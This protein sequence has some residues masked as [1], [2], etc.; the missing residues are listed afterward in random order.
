MSTPTDKT[1][2]SESEPN[3]AHERCA[4]PLPDQAKKR[5]AQRKRPVHSKPRNPRYVSARRSDGGLFYVRRLP[6]ALINAGLFPAQNPTIRLALGTKDW[7]IAQAKARQMTA[8]FDREWSR[9]VKNLKTAAPAGIPANA[10][11]LRADDIPV[12]SRRLES[13]LVHT[14][15]VDRSRV[16]SADDFETYDSDLATQRKQLR[17]ANQRG[18]VAAVAEE[19]LGFLEAEG[20][21]CEPSSPMWTDWLRAVLQAHLSALSRIASRLD[22]EAVPTPPPVAPMRSEDDL[23]DLDRALVYWQTKTGPQ[24]KTV[25]EMRSCVER[26]RLATGRTRISAVRPDDVVTFM[27]VERERPSAR[28]GQVNVQT[29]NKGLALLKAL[30]SLV[31]ADYLSAQNV[32]NPLSSIK[33][34]RVRARDVARRKQ[35]SEEQLVR[36]FSGPVH[37]AASRPAGGAGEAAYWAPVLGYTSGARMQE[38]LQA[39]VSDVVMMDGVVLLRTETEDDEDDEDTDVD[40]KE[41]DAR[42]CSRRSLKTSE[43]YRFIPLHRDVLALGFM[44]YVEWVRDAGHVQ[45][46][47]DVRVGIH[48]SWSANFSKFF[49]RYLKQRG[50]KERLLDWI[51]FRHGFKTQTRAIELMKSDVADYIQGH[52]AERASQNYGHF[53]AEVLEYSINLMSFPALAQVRPWTPPARR[54]MPGAMPTFNVKQS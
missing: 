7:L 2:A 44:N 52:A 4:A 42:S 26:F 25:I 34:F 3:N 10:R 13:L 19:A 51:S 46:F 36:L 20:L 15:D 41:G 31:H 37:V 45:L 53:P 40:F 12:L 21:E 6:Q 47:P 50:V 11:R 48:D 32:A 22:G 54:R 27:R 24:P 5:L 49:N 14:D 39:K 28:G 16:L 17:H 9:L 43:S 35:F 18:D 29:V 30:F 38:L 23:D 1:S 8:E 33:K